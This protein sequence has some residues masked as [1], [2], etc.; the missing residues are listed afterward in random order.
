VSVDALN[1]AFSGKLG[2]GLVNTEGALRQ[3]LPATDLGFALAGSTSP[4][5]HA[6]GGVLKNKPF[7]VTISGGPPGALSALLVGTAPVFAPGFGGTVVP[8]INQMLIVFLDGD[9]R[10][11]LEF[12]LPVALPPGVPVAWLQALVKDTGAPFGVALT[13]ALVLENP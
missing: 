7:A 12:P 5:L 2:A 9:G 8:Q 10:W 1:P 4:R 6:Y 13:N 3:L 11:H